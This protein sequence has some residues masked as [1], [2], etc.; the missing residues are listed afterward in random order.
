MRGKSPASRVRRSRP[1]KTQE[2]GARETDSDGESSLLTLGTPIGCTLTHH[3]VADGRATNPTGLTLAVVN[4]EPLLEVSGVALGVEEV[5][6]G[7]ATLLDGFGEHLAN[8]A[9]QFLQS[10]FAQTPG[11]G[12]R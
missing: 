7:G 4:E 12:A 10:G 5:A 8:G 3:R 9:H 1:K 6:Q 11:G 2:H